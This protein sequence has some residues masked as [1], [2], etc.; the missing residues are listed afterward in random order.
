MEPLIVYHDCLNGATSSDLLRVA[1]G[2]K[3]LA[4]GALLR[5]REPEPARC[6]PMLC[7]RC[8]W[9]LEPCREL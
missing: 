9:P 7:V 2:V 4:C 3:C 8:N 6:D 5:E 1:D